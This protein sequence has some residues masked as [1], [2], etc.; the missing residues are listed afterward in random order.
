MIFRSVVPVVLLCGIMM[1]SGSCSP[2]TSDGYIR[3]TASAAN[4][5]IMLV[6]SEPVTFGH[7]RLS[8]LSHLYPD[9][10]IFLRSKGYP[11]FLAET[12]KGGSRYLILYYLDQREA[13]A[14]RSGIGKSRE[15]EFSGPY[16]ITDS[17]AKTLGELLEKSEGV[18]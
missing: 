1:W 12:N 15:A 16:P 8:A 17:E 4:D 10:G 7:T 14:C 6:R 18:S 5:R 13:Y 11:G 9:L 2:A 3:R